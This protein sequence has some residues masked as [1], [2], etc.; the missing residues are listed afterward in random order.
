[1]AVDS[2]LERLYR[3]DLQDRERYHSQLLSL[4][5][6]K[7]NDRQRL[8]RL[9]ALIGQF[10]E[11]EIWNCHYACLLL[12]HSWKTKH[13]DY[14][15]AHYYA[16]KAVD[17]GSR[18]TRWLYAAS[19]DR[20][21]IAQGKKQLFGTQFIQKNGRWKLLPVD[22]QITNAERAEY[23]VPP[24]HKALQVFKKNI[25]FDRN[26]VRRIF[27]LLQLLTECKSSNR[28]F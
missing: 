16:K 23:G 25:S 22:G 11:T 26:G 8:K 21:L 9:K 17:Q 3:E 10:D 19:K 18:V 12:M 2:K 27:P 5:D 7:Q 24:L 4:E 15:L 1:V 20:M 14:A 13:S 28:L 6:L